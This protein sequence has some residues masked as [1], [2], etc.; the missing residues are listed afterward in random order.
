V[1]NLKVFSVA[2]VLP[3]G[4]G[5]FIHGKVVTTALNAFM[6]SADRRIAPHHVPN[7]FKNTKGLVQ[8]LDAKEKAVR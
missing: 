8:T 1:P 5:G 7:T 2:K 4:R 3:A 6:A